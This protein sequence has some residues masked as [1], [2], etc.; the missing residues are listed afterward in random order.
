MH[1]LLFLTIIACFGFVANSQAQQS[2][3]QWETSPRAAAAKAES[4][5][6]LVMLH[7]TADWC[8]PCQNLK[9]FV[10]SSPSVA[11]AI[12]Q[13]AVPVI[14]DIDAN[15]E[16]AQQLGVVSIPYDVFLTP[17]GEVFTRHS[18]PKDSSNFLQL[19]NSINY[20]PGLAPVASSALDQ[21][22]RKA[23]P[24]AMAETDRSDF[25]ANG[26]SAVN[27]GGYSKEGRALASQS[28]YPQMVN[29]Q[30]PQQTTKSPQASLQDA[31]AGLAGGLSDNAPQSAKPAASRF[32]KIPEKRLENPSAAYHPA[33]NEFHPQRVNEHFD[34]EAFLA[35]QRPGLT[36]PAQARSVAPVRVSNDQF[37][38]AANEAKMNSATKIPGLQV[39]EMFN[40]AGQTIDPQVKGRS[41]ARIQKE[42]T[43]QPA[44]PAAHATIVAD[45]NARIKSYKENQNEFAQQASMVKADVVNSSVMESNPARAGVDEMAL[46]GKCPVALIE[47]GQWVEGDVRW[48][49]V[50]RDRTYLFSSVANYELFKQD[51][52]RYSPILSG[53][54]PVVFHE[55]GKL[56]DGMEENGVFMGK[57]NKQ[58]IV[59][60]QSPKTRAKFQ[61]NPKLYMNTVRQA[62]HS[63]SRES[64][65]KTDSM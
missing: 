19:C 28:N 58:Q 12:H 13:K 43:Q 3:I 9:R 36:V 46:H 48:G 61:A 63:A 15:K 20:T 33:T 21:F 18:S 40:A 35:K 23:A 39:S 37:F 55:Q 42:E 32:F 57:N 34:R 26:P 4:E 6:K 56:I 27:A 7:F 25:R 30:R 10:F 52:D 11:R 24:M 41:L 64:I 1:K 44:T 51:P 5:S 54:D 47:Q 60:F 8:G 45:S 38:A 2:P 59:L 16:L 17:S 22:K 62:L 53:F 31:L 29:Q 65:G 50:H 49:I 14:V